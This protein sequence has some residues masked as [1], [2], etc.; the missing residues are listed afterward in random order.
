MESKPEENKQQNLTGLEILKDKTFS[1]LEGYP[2]FSFY[3]VDDEE[4]ECEGGSKEK[5][6]LI[7]MMYTIG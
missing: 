3:T 2:Y 4:E 7:Y 6:P 5:A 1:C